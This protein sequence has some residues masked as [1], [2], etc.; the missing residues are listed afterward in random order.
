MS[1]PPPALADV[2]TPQRSV[3]Q[4]DSVSLKM[5]L[6][7]AWLLRD[8]RALAWTTVTVTG[9]SSA[10]STTQGVTPA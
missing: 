10:T 6:P 4:T 7:L 2:A 3:F 9:G 1:A 8:T 5:K